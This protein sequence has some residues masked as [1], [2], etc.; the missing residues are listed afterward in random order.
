MAASPTE[1]ESNS[2]PVTTKFE[3]NEL[4]TLLIELMPTP[5]SPR[6]YQPLTGGGGGASTGGGGGKSRSA[7]WAAPMAPIATAPA[8]ITALKL[9]IT[10]NPFMGAGAGVGR[11]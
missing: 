9:A 3:S 4:F 6:R 2:S 10:I 5:T 11:R 8:T 1:R 7:A